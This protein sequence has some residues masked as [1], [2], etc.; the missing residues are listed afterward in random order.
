M[1]LSLVLNAPPGPPPSSAETLD[2]LNLEEL[3][4]RYAKMPEARELNG[5]RVADAQ[6]VYDR[7]RA[8]FRPLN[9]GL[10]SAELR[11]VGR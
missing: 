6:S 3:A 7:Y 2:R 1:L 5:L 11:R 10:D 8:F 9:G 4:S